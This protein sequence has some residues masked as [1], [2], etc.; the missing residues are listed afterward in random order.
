MGKSLR[1]YVAAPWDFRQEARALRD[2]L[3]SS[4]YYVTSRWLDIDETKTTQE[5]ESWND[6]H[7]VHLSEAMVVLNLKVSEGKAV[8][9]G[10]AMEMQIPI[11]VVSDHGPQNVFQH[12][13]QHFTIV[14]DYAALFEKLATL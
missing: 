5:E 10:I 11:I 2:Q 13:R 12:N 9:Q 7:D 4:G 8:E 14:P 3:I 1:I 6:I